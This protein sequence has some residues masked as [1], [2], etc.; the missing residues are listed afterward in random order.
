MF[1]AAYGGGWRAGMAPKTLLI[2]PDGTKIITPP[3]CPYTKR[4]QVISR[5]MWWEGYHAGLRKSLNV[6]LAT[7]SRNGVAI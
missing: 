2:R 3:H 5:M 6:W 7:R 1:K 4:T